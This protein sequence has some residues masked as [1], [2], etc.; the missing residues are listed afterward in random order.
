M[1]HG[2]RKHVARGVCSAKGMAFTQWDAAEAARIRLGGE[3][4][5]RGDCCGYLHITRY[6]EGEYAQRVAL[7]CTDPDPYGMVGYNDTDEGEDDGEEQAGDARGE[8]RGDAGRP[9]A[10]SLKRG[11]APRPTATPA[12]VAR[13]FEG[14]SDPRL[15]A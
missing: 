8:P 12:E 5:Y 14:R 11:E 2:V 7:G 1:A 3:R 9:R 15:R 10:S 6:T 4:V 13:F